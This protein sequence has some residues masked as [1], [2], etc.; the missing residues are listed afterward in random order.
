MDEAVIRAINRI[1]QDIEKLSAEQGLESDD[2]Q[3]LIAARDD[4]AILYSLVPST[5]DLYALFCRR[6]ARLMDYNESFKTRDWDY[7]HQELLYVLQE[8]YIPLEEQD[9]T[10]FSSLFKLEG[11]L[12]QREMQSQK[13]VG[14]FKNFHEL[15]QTHR[16]FLDQYL[17]RCISLH[18]KLQVEGLVENVED[19]LR[20]HY[21]QNDI[22]LSSQTKDRLQT[23]LRSVQIPLECSYKYLLQ[24]CSMSYFSKL[25]SHE[26]LKDDQNFFLP[27]MEEMS[28]SSDEGILEIYERLQE[29]R[30]MVILGDVGSAKTTAM[31]LLTQLFAKEALGGNERVLIKQIDCGPVRI[32]ILIRITSLPSG[33]MTIQVWL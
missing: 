22:Q 26:E 10:K 18:S 15:V 16:D 7:L 9:Y 21:Q 1:N 14:E 4:L 17:P 20:N 32:P 25:P 28:I 11:V 12:Q 2:C 29:S 13:T 31:R 33:S 30:W 24:G 3:K 27:G 8:Y 5:K 19:L 23:E 6:L